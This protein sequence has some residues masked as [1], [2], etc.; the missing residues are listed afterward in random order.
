MTLVRC[1]ICVVT[2][3]GALGGCASVDV[4]AWEKSALAKPSMVFDGNVLEAR[5]ADHT[6]QSKEGSRGNGSVGGGGCGCN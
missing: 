3:A 5:F 2:L 6:F 1:L 4:K